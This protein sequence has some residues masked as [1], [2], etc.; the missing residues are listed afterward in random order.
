MYIFGVARLSVLS[1]DGYI[2]GFLLQLLLKIMRECVGILYR[3]FSW[4]LTGD[5]LSGKSRIYSKSEHPHFSFIYLFFFS[6]L[7][8]VIKHTKGEKKRNAFQFHLSE[9]REN[10]C[11]NVDFSYVTEDWINRNLWNEG[12]FGHS[13]V[14]W[15]KE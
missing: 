1:L 15:L 2:K 12:E 7:V 14:N 8:F 13:M 6:F 10:L 9:E 3:Y 11:D 4:F 5:I